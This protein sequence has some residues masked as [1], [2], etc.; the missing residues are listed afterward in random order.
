MN[1]GQSIV[2][3]TTA[4]PYEIDSIELHFNSGNTVNKARLAVTFGTA[5]ITAA[6]EEGTIAY[7]AGNLVQT[8]DC[9]VEGATFFRIEHTTTNVLYL[10][11]I[12]INFVANA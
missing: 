12:V 5:E 11:S 9:D 7:D 1:K 10:D 3:N 2:R 8:I 6:A 4:T